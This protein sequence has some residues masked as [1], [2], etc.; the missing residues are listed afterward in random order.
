MFIFISTTRQNMKIWISNFEI[1][2]VYHQLVKTMKLNLLIDI[3]WTSW[4]TNKLYMFH[5]DTFV[6]SKYVNTLKVRD[7]LAL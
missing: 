4:L 7:I 1:I 3:I 2:D 6:V 5:L